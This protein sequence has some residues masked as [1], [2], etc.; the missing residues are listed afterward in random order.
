MHAPYV[1]RGAG[2]SAAPAPPSRV[3]AQSNRSTIG[4]DPM[5]V[6]FMKHI[7]VYCMCHF[8]STCGEGKCP[9]SFPRTRRH[10]KF[11]RARR[12]SLCLREHA[13]VNAAWR[14]A[15]GIPKSRLRLKQTVNILR[16]FGRCK[17]VTGWVGGYNLH[18]KLVF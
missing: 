9:T 1:Q 15:S 7:L 8:F 17:G 6:H 5:R 18:V 10:T 14:S 12:G 16:V 11:T 4:T 13:T 2:M 3:L